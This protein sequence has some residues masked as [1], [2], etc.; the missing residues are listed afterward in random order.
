MRAVEF[1]EGDW[2]NVSRPLTLK[3]LAG[4][5]VVLD[6]WTYCCIN[7][8]HVLASLDALERA[9]P[10][11][12][13]VVGVHSPKFTTEHDAR[14]VREAVLRC[15]IKH[16][17]LN[18][19]DMTLWQQ[20]GIRAWPSLLF[21]DPRGEILGQYPGEVP[22]GVLI[23]FVDGALEEH[24]ADIHP[25]PLPIALEADRI[26]PGPLSF[27]GKVITA[28]GRLYLSDSGHNRVLEMSLEGE[29]ERVFEGE[30]HSPQG[31][32]IADGRL[33]VADTENHALK[34]IDLQSGKV[35]LAAGSG[36]QGNQRQVSATGPEVALS[37]PWDLEVVGQQLFIAMAGTHQLWVLDLSSGVV[38]DWAGSGQENISDGPLKQAQLAQPSGICSDGRVL[39]FVDSETS[40]VR[41]AA[42]EPDGWVRTIVG[43]GLFDF[44]DQDGIGGEV[45]LQHP[46]GLA[47]ADN[48]LY[49]ADTYNNKVKR[50]FPV[51][52]GVTTLLGSGQAGMAD[53]QGEL[54]ELNEPGG[55]AV[56]DDQL[57]VADTN[58][59]LLRVCDLN[60]T[61]TRTL[62]I[63]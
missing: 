37:S 40:S 30:F 33:Y 55:L 46:L 49:V 42:L 3:D 48:F 53:G 31:L 8:H 59:S 39:Y 20:Y 5:M 54:V 44:G 17:V 38:T 4:R 52:R 12:V 1:P 47:C 56:W 21:I 24:Q 61:Q 58:N 51:N 35:G 25:R 2:F 45:R 43:R 10:E 14:N 7:C 19:P 28:A 26:P 6:F 18:D 23:G 9:H 50:V 32:A 11:D 60:T 62:E 16:P 15:G 41:A 63:R 27:P 29:I 34:T 22:P 13:V 57:Y 36:E